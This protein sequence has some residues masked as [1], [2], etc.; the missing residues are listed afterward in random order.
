V[1]GTKRQLVWLKVRETP[2]QIAYGALSCVYGA[3]ALLAG[4][5][6]TPS[7]LDNTM[8]RWVVVAWCLALF[9]GGSLMLLGRL[10]SYGE[11]E[12]AGLCIQL[13]GILCYLAGCCVALTN[14]G[15]ALFGLMSYTALGA[16]T[17]VRLST[18][19]EAIRAR[20]GALD[21]GD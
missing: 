7:N 13:G 5:G 21:M 2:Y 10:L 17:M 16:A 9:V 3:G 11:I 15:S 1:V 18:V 8:P 12:A 14:G 20:D 19:R 6:A 4:V